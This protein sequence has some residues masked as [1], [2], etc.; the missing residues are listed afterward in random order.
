M[1]GKTALDYWPRKC[2]VVFL[3]TAVILELRREISNCWHCLV[4]SEPLGT[5][6]ESAS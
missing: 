1:A 5:L 2:V 4:I 3:S 6:D